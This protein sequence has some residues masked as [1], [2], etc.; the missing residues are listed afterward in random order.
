MKMKEDK[1]PVTSEAKVE[2]GTAYTS[3]EHQLS[4]CADGDNGSHQQIH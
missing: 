4:A 1:G 3:H 2:Q